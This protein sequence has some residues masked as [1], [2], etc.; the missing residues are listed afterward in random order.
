MT[1]GV[2]RTIP[3]FSYSNKVSKSTGNNS[4]T[5]TV[6]TSTKFLSFPSFFNKRCTVDF[7]TACSEYSNS[8]DADYVLA[9][10][11]YDGTALSTAFECEITVAYDLALEAHIKSV[12]PNND[13]IEQAE[14][15][16]SVTMYHASR[17]AVSGGYIR[18]FTLNV[19]ARCP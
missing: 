14:D 8:A 1:Y 3:G 7:S 2:G 11:D 10:H 12:E 19:I 6:R 9:I 5:R 4:D 13:L 15:K 18:S 16:Y 17:N